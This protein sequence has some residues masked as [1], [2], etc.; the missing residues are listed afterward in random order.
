[1]LV[2][3]GG[4][5]SMT[6]EETNSYINQI[7]SNFSV[8]LVKERFDESLLV[9]KNLFCWDYQD[10]LYFKPQNT[11]R[12]PKL[13]ENPDIE[14]LREKHYRD[15]SPFDYILYERATEKLD[16]QMESIANFSHQL[17]EFKRLRETVGHVCDQLTED[18]ESVN[19]KIFI[20]N[21]NFSIGGE[22]CVKA[23]RNLLD[24]IQLFKNKYDETWQFGLFSE[25]VIF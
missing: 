3:F 5:R 12:R 21:L 19:H 4:K 15:F 9:M 22:F 6:H 20:A 25:T 13:V 17:Q 8:I 2:D 23:R 1:M 16:K 11:F 14:S 7:F 10:I 18:S 24:Y